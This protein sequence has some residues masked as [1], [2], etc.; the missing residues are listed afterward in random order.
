MQCEESRDNWSTCCTS[1]SHAARR[2]HAVTSPHT[3][4]HTHISTDALRRCEKQKKTERRTIHNNLQEAL[5][6]PRMACARSSH[7]SLT[8]SSINDFLASLSTSFTLERLRRLQVV[9]MA[10][11]RE[12]R[13]E[14][15]TLP[16]EESS[17][18]ARAVAAE[19][20]AARF[21][22]AACAIAM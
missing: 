22:Q 17:S 21:A 5:R 15:F 11:I 4:T 7:A 2:Q 3:H 6:S 10:P 20:D 9:L 18:E 14:V 8:L 12:P 19:M 1:L 13:V 16:V